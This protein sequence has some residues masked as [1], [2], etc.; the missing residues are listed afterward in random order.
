[1]YVVISVLFYG[2]K[3]KKK[4]K[5]FKKTMKRINVFALPANCLYKFITHINK[6]FFFF[7]NTIIYMSTFQEY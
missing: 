4:I 5:R 6:S 2:K 3:T 1:M 7:R